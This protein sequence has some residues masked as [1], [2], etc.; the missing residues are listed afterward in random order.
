MREEVL[1]ILF[2]YLEIDRMRKY[3]YVVE[4]VMRELVKRLE[5][6]KEEEWVVVGFLYDLDLDIVGRKLGE[7]CE[8]YVI[9]IVELFKKENFGDEEMYRVIFGYYD[10]MGV[11][12]ISLMEKVIYVVDFIIGFIIVIVLVYLDKKFISVKI[13][14]VIKRMKEMRFVLN[15]N[16]DVMRSIED[17]GILFDEF[18]EFFFNVMKNISDV[19]ESVENN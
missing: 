11:I 15:V 16:R 7:I 17:I 18:V 9:I 10:G 6:E 14:F 3:C 5:L 4:V 8:G 13:K 2:K 12:R 19:F 1:E